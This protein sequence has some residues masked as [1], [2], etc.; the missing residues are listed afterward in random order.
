MTRVMKMMTMSINTGD[1]PGGAPTTVTT[2]HPG[3]SGEAIA[4]VSEVDTVEV[5]GPSK[6]KV[7]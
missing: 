4:E 3:A 2:T 7:Q 5:T 6:T 1:H